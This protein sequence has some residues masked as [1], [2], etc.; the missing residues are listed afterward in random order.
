MILYLQFHSIAPA[1][2]S[3]QKKFDEFLIPEGADDRDD[4]GWPHGAGGFPKDNI[5]LIVC[6]LIVVLNQA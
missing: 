6:R 5:T 4:G 2:A 3:C 1:L